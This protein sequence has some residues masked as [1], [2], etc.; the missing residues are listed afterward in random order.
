MYSRDETVLAVLE[1][2]QQLI[3]HPYL[4]SSALIL[5]PSRGWPTLH[6]SIDSSKNPTVRS[7]LKHL[8]YLRPEK[9]NERLCVHWE[10]IPINHSSDQDT[11]SSFA[12]SV[13]PLPD[14]C[15]YLT[16]SV[17]REGTAL[18]LDTNE[19]IITDMGPRSHIEV[20]HEEYDALPLAE[21]WTKHRRTPIKEFLDAWTERY[22]KIV[23]V[24]V[25]NP[26]GRPMSGRF[27]SRAE[28]PAVEEELLRLQGPWQYQVEEGVSEAIERQS[29]HAAVGPL[30]N[31]AFSHQ[32]SWEG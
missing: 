27:Y 9:A 29:K 30:K 23:W 4:P 16:R 25:P 8:P 12:E 21:K 6:P 22:K 11:G 26:V 14:H 24:L 20:P 15:V 1:L 18:I 10:T 2:Y 7:L 5:P 17:D 28:R 19:G 31:L 3:L 32:N 13:Y